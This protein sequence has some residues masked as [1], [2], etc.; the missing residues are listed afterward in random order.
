[1]YGIFLYLGFNRQDDHAK[2]TTIVY[3]LTLKEQLEMCLQK[4][5]VADN[6]VFIDMH[7]WEESQLEKGYSTKGTG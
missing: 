4:L 3:V 7:P 1:M 2:G 5:N 6:S